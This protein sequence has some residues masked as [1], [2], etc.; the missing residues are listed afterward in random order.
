M[1]ITF[2]N[3]NVLRQPFTNTKDMHTKYIPMHLSAKVVDGGITQCSMHNCYLLKQNS[4][5]SERTFPLPGGYCDAIGRRSRSSLF[6]YMFTFCCTKA[7]QRGQ[8]L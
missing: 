3:A 1:K 5:A 2:A 8:Q 6:M 7:N 4:C